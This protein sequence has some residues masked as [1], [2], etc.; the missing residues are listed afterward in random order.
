MPGG[1]A[2][3]AA[4]L[5]ET[6]RA[7]GGFAVL[8]EMRNASK[9]G[10]ALGNVSDTEGKR[11]EAS[12]AALAKA[13]SYEQVVQQLK[14]I[15]AHNE[16][17]KQRIRDAYNDHWNN[18]GAAAKQTMGGGP[19]RIRDDSDYARLPA[20]AQYIDPEGNPRTKR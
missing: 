3:D 18:A 17:S 7:R 16:A 19:A 20:G 14:N 4:A 13:S 1:K 15:I 5:L 11:L 8:Q 2:A 10:G 9:T 6:L 12:M